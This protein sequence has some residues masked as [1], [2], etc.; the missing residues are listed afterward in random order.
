MINEERIVHASPEAVWA[1]MSDVARWPD[2]LSTVDKVRPLYAA[3]G[4]VGSRFA[5]KQPGI[6]ELTYEVTQWVPDENFTWVAKSPGVRTV[7]RHLIS[8]AEGGARLRVS[9]EWQGPL[10]KVI[11]VL[12]GTRTANFVRVEADTF[13]ASA[14][15]E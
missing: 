2:L 7:G 11:A 12:F 13:A 5:L 10:S 1:V 6:P 15:R 14:A 9:L 3:A 4:G 8:A